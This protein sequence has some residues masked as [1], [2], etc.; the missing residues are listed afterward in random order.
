M[1]RKVIKGVD[2][3]NLGKPSHPEASSL[4]GASPFF[5]QPEMGAVRFQVQTIGHRPLPSAARVRPG[6][7]SARRQDSHNDLT[8]CRMAWHFVS[9]GR[10]RAALRP[11]ARPYAYAGVV[12]LRSALTLP[13]FPVCSSMVA[14]ESPANSR[15][16]P[17]ATRP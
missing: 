5:A 17:R 15:T 3:E 10:S 1:P 2:G 12:A 9:D 8:P 4:N 11:N 14:W 16:P 13:R 7:H 6:A